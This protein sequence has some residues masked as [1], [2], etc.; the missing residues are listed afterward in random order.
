MTEATSY[1]YGIHILA[2]AFFRLEVEIQAQL[3]NF[4]EIV[5]LW[6]EAIRLHLEAI[7]T[8]LY[9]RIICDM[10]TWFGSDSCGFIS[11]KT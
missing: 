11:Y 3:R 2:L 9:L 7:M 4:F 6:D 5:F 8:D 10:I 1:P